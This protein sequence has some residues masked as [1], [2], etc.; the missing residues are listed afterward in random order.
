MGSRVG[1]E[2]SSRTSIEIE[3][4]EKVRSLMLDNIEN[5]GPKWDIHLPLFLSPASL[6]RV[7][8]LDKV[9]RKG[10]KVQGNLV[11]FGSQWGASFAVFNLLKRIHSGIA[12]DNYSH[13][14]F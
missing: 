1:K 2:L 8:W 6:A 10:L 5:F 3:N 12:P 14:H 11:E 9:Y 7:L 13:F 4:T